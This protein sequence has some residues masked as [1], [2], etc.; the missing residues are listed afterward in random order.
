MGG[1]S[2]AELSQAEL[3]AIF[4]EAEAATGMTV[5]RA[6]G[7]AHLQVSDV[8]ELGRRRNPGAVDLE[9]Q[10]DRFVAARGGE[11]TAIVDPYRAVADLFRR[12]VGR[13]AVGRNHLYVL[14]KPKGASGD[15]ESPSVPAGT[16]GT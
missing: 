11:R 8:L 5:L 4:Q 15:P 1:E 3:S 6:A 9:G 10:L 13:S 2:G 14:P 12:L 16:G 7:A